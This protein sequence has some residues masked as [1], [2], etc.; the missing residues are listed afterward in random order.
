MAVIFFTGDPLDARG[1]DDP[2]Y[3]RTDA[4]EPAVVEHVVDMLLALAEPGG[5]LI[6]PGHSPIAACS[7]PRSTDMSTHLD[8]FSSSRVRGPYAR[9]RKSSHAHRS[10]SFGAAPVAAKAATSEPS[11]LLKITKSRVVVTSRR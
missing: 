4:L 7:A 9:P 5:N 3:A 6:D 8:T 11:G 1:V 2:P 10:N